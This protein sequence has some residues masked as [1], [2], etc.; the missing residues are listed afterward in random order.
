MRWV[1]LVSYNGSQFHGFGVQPGGVETVGGALMSALS[2]VFQRQ[3]DIVVAG[4]TDKGV[5]AVGQVISFDAPDPRSKAPLRSI[6]RLLPSSVKVHALET[7][8]D[9]FS[10]RFSARYRLYLYRIV[11]NNSGTPFL[12]DLS[13][14]IQEPL[15]VKKMINASFALVGSHDFRA[16]CKSGGNDGRPTRRRLYGVEIVESDHFVDILIWSNSFCHQMVRSIVSVLVEV[17]LGRRQG[18]VLRQALV[19]GDRSLVHS[20]APP[21]G[22]Y[23]FGVGYQS[24]DPLSRRLWLERTN[25]W[26]FSGPTWGIERI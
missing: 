12:K 1:A 17:G 6:N 3:I 20:V 26:D 22:L 8:V 25:S 15:D 16:F 14:A 23:L 4:R 18:V 24:F 11:K 5:H 21:E 13:W 10:A 19:S 7:T 9:S 2:V